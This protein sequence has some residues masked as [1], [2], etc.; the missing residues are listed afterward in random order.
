KSNI[1]YKIPMI[2]EELLRQET[3]FHVSNLKKCLSD[4]PLVIPLDEIH[5][6]DKLNFIEEP[7]EIMDHEVKRLN[8]I[9]IPIIK[10]CWNSRRVK[11]NDSMEKLTRQYLKEVVS[12]HG[13]PVSIIFDRDGS[14]NFMVYCGASHKGLGA[15]LMQ[16]EKVI[17]YAS[18]QLKI[19]ENNYT[20]HDLELGAMVFALKTW[21]H[22]LYGMRCVVFID[23]KSL[24]HI[25]DQ[26]ELN[27]R[28]RRWLE[29]LSDYDCEIRY[30]LRKGNVV[31]DALSRKVRPKPLRVRALVL[32]IG[33]NLP[34]QILKAQIEAKKEENYRAEDL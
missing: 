30:H 9:R 31:A 24:Q 7:V 2:E 34:M 13:V 19:H 25:L 33:L 23:H 18:R 17:A 20:M 12:K 11:E 22:Y 4:D 3:T 21:I 5:I 8:Q 28:K 14:E 10:V 16:K 32:T 6:D 29:L 15:I 27:M 1:I 26:K